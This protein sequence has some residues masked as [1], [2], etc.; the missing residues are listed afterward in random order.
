MAFEERRRGP[1]VQTLAG[2]EL[3]LDKRVRVRLVDISAE[4]ALLACD[5]RV[6]PAT[7][8]RLRVALGNEPFEAPSKSSGKNGAPNHR[9]SW[10]R[11]LSA[12]VVEVR[13]H[14]ISFWDGLN[15]QTTGVSQR[16]SE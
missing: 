4:G 11:R 14:S 2:P 12:W 10:E 7:V 1:R 15:S 6:P 16:N 8:G 3:R 5:E 13:M 9:R